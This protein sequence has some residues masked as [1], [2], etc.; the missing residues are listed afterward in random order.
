MGLSLAISM[1][2][3][4][5]DNPWQSHRWVLKSV[6]ADLGQ[7]DQPKK[8]EVPIGREM[9]TAHQLDQTSADEWVYRGFHI[10]LF[11][12]EAEGYYLNV[13]SPEPSWFVMWRIEESEFH[14]SH[15]IAIPYRVMLSYNEAGRLLDG[16]EQVDRFVLSG[17]ILK[18]IE[19]YVAEYYRPEPKR[20]IRPASFE[21]AY[22]P[23]EKL[24]GDSK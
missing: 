23:K 13:S 5:L 17:E 4:A 22:R 16:G 9:I 12:D 20:R 19:D 3:E 21:G 2:C 11:V 1:R 6:E 7:Y 10:D 15:E 24:S 18:S 8:F 14:P